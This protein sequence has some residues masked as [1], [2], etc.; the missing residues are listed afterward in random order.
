MTPPRAVRVQR[1]RDVVHARFP[2]WP[3][4]RSR[5]AAACIAA[6][7]LSVGCGG[8]RPLDPAPEPPNPWPVDNLVADGPDAVAPQVRARFDE[9]VPERVTLRCE[10][11]TTATVQVRAAFATL[12]DVALPCS[13]EADDGRSW[14]LGS[15]TLLR[16]AGATADAS[17]RCEAEGT[18]PAAEPATPAPADDA[19]PE[20]A[21][22]SAPSAAEGASTEGA[23]EAGSGS[24]QDEV[25]ENAPL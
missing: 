18:P 21:A 25:P 22:P 16:C 3:R 20:G 4:S 17:G 13:L 2:R 9:P 8:S 15:G 14:A 12:R 11:G 23:E 1:C 5:A 24:A 6:G 10:G 7:V 19:S